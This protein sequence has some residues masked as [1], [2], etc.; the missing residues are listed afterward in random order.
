MTWHGLEE[1]PNSQKEWE[2]DQKAEPLTQVGFIPSS[3]EFKF[4]KGHN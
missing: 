3:F 1:V 4:N 2:R